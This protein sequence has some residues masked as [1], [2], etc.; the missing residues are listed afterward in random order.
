MSPCC[1]QMPVCPPSQAQ[2]VASRSPESG[3]L[4]QEG[5]SSSSGNSLGVAVCPTH[6]FAGSLS[7]QCCPCW[8]RHGGHRGSHRGT[9]EPGAPGTSRQGGRRS[10]EGRVWPSWAQPGPW[11][12]NL[13]GDERQMCVA[14][15]PRSPSPNPSPATLSLCEVS[16]SWPLP[17]V[18]PASSGSG[19]CT[20]SFEQGCT[21][22]RV[23]VCR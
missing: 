13:G 16:S 22:R 12:C 4:S 23:T 2:R 20:W 1:F 3:T 11:P 6:Q 8:E 17:W 7:Q 18:H 15:T 9:H 14:Q 21:Q 10:W 19:S 5:S